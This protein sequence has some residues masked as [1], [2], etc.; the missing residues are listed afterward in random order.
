MH[1]E[2]EDSLLSIFNTTKSFISFENSKFNFKLSRHNFVENKIKDIYICVELIYND[3]IPI[4]Q[5]LDYKNSPI[6]AAG[7]VYND[8]VLCHNIPTYKATKETGIFYAQSIVQYLNSL[9]YR[10]NSQEILVSSLGESDLVELEEI[11]HGN[12]YLLIDDELKNIYIGKQYKYIQRDQ[13]TKHAASFIH[14]SNASHMD[15]VWSVKIINDKITLVQINPK[16]NNEIIATFQSIKIQISPNKN[17]KKNVSIIGL[18]SL[19]SYF[20]ANFVKDYQNGKLY[21]IDGDYFL[22]TNQ[23]RHYMGYSQNVMF[24][25]KAFALAELLGREIIKHRDINQIIPLFEPVGLRTHAKMF[26]KTLEYLEKS[27][28]IIDLTGTNEVLKAILKIDLKEKSVYKAALYDGGNVMIV[29]RVDDN[30][31]YEQIM[32]EWE[33]RRK[34]YG[35]EAE[36]AY[37]SENPANNSRV[38]LM[39][40]VLNELIESNDIKKGE[41]LIYD[42]RN[43]LTKA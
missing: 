28:E 37:T 40:S 41:F 13:T 7:H 23:N 6:S 14:D 16:T 12:F 15:S 17:S 36:S 25:S 30:S 11:S 34:E 3:E 2:F 8:G 10:K 4:F 19:G 22:A 26:S 21:L 9:Q 35:Y 38:S 43:N 29:L 42:W 20:A 1:R 24:R 27:N 39:S 32:N 31:T 33:K 5:I 18:G